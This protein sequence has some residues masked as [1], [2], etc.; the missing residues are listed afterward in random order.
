LFED[1]VDCNRQHPI[2]CTVAY[3]STKSTN[4]LII[5]A[6]RT[7]PQKNLIDTA[8]PRDRRQMNHQS[9]P[10]SNIENTIVAIRQVNY[11]D[12]P[13]TTEN[14]IVTMVLS[15]QALGLNILLSPE[16]HERNGTQR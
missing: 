14:T 9:D 4:H 6:K 15:M 7:Q 12:P 16:F 5:T 13:F 1:W 11:S 2:N 3:A 10:A 8:K